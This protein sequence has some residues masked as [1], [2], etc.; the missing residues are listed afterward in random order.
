MCERQL[1]VYE[2]TKVTPIIRLQFLGTSKT[3]IYEGGS[4][5]N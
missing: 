4:H 1:Q 2:K 3:K 5:V